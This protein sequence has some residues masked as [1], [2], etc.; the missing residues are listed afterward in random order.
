MTG[1]GF[2]S[3][4]SALMSGMAAT[5]ISRARAASPSRNAW[6]ISCTSAG[7]TSAPT[8]M[9]PEAPSAMR[10]TVSASSPEYMRKPSESSCAASAANETFPLASLRPMMLGWALRRSRLRMLIEQPQRPGML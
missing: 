4:K 2:T 7:W 10:G 6:H 3:L 1:I 5:W 8:E 9:V